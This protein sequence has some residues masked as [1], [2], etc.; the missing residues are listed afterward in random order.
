MLR[1]SLP[2]DKVLFDM[3]SAEKLTPQNLEAEQS[4]LGSLL[5]DKDA[6][7]KAGDRVQVDDFYA[8]KHRVI[9]KP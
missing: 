2:R 8:D 5:I 3:N 9:L 7:I 6:I 1:C 4:L